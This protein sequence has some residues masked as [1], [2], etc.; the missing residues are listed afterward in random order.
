MLTIRPAQ[1]TDKKELLKILKTLDLFYPSLSLKNFWVAEKNRKIIGVVQ[2]KKYADFLFLSSLG[3]IEGERK[4]GIGAALLRE[5]LKNAKKNVYLYT[6]QPEF[7]KKFGFEI[8]PS[9]PKLPSKKPLECQSCIPE[10]CV[11][12]VKLTDVA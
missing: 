1:E 2:L 6:I 7:F 10:K 3:I 4:L 5:I 8:I 12:M 11:C 9:S